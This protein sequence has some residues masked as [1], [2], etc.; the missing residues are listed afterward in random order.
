VTPGPDTGREPPAGPGAPAGAAQ[1][2][3][4]VILEDRDGVTVAA[5]SGEVDISNAAMVSRTLTGLPNLAHGLV[6]DLSAVEYLDSTGI[7]LL[8]EL[9]VRLRQRSQRL[10]VVCPAQAPPRRVLELTALHSTVTILDDLPPAI[11]A[12]RDSAQ[13][14]PPHG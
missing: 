3:A 9:A 5:I 10:I 6:V 13:D 14:L 8:H 11:Q 12:L 1:D 4:R 2:L 7:S